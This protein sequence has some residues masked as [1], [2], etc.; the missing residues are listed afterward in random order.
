MSANILL[1]GSTDRQLELALAACGMKTPSAPGSE[2]AALAQPG[3]KQPDVLVLDLQDQTHLPS[4]LPLLKRQHPT[5]GVVIVTPR[6]DPALL[7]EAMRVGVTEV[8]STITQEDLKAAIDRLMALKPVTT[9]AGKTYAFVGA[10]GG[11][12]TTTVA[13]N[14]ATAL[15]KLEPHSTLLIDLH[16]ANGDAA[17]F[18][19]AEPRFSIVDALENT[20]RLDEAFFKNLIVH[21]KCGVDL[22]GVVRPRDADASGCPAGS[23]DS[24]SGRAPLSSCRVG[25]PALRCGNARWARVGCPHCRGREPGAGDG[26]ERQ[27]DCD[28]DASALRQGQS[29][30]S[31]SV[32]RTALPTSATRISSAP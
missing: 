31:S 3:A 13:V 20:H 18:L 19:G 21:A 1:I 14:V 30:A 8:V 10:K 2:L 22:L 17:V 24:R 11:V 27:P 29:H 4:A 25:R 28:G 23:N 9:V 26:P 5:T 12:G 15:A 7:L 16:V 6:L 32:A